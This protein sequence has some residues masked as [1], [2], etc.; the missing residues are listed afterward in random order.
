ML[1]RAAEPTDGLRYGAG[2]SQFYT[3]VDSECHDRV[4]ALKPQT[5]QRADTT[6]YLGNSTFYEVSHL[7]KAK[8]CAFYGNPQ[9]QGFCSK[10]FKLMELPLD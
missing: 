8:G 6:L 9:T 4:S 5:L 1:K 10:C 2:N 3:E 7:C